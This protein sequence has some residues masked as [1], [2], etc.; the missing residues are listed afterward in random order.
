MRF[1][2][3]PTA[4]MSPCRPAHLFLLFVGLIAVVV[5]GSA[6]EDAA[7]ARLAR[8]VAHESVPAMPYEL[9]SL[10]T[11]A[12]GDDEGKLVPAIFA[13]D[14]DVRVVYFRHVSKWM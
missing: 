10:D 6:R 12:E 9:V 2:S 8:P 5:L 7:D 14:P 3:R 11:S 4:S 1:V 13:W